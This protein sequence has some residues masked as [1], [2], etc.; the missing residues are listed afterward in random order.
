MDACLSRREKSR[1]DDGQDVEDTGLTACEWTCLLLLDALLLIG[2]AIAASLWGPVL[3]FGCKGLLC[4]TKVSHMR[5]VRPCMQSCS[6]AKF[7]LTRNS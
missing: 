7:M 5:H 1:D 3:L 2:G 6:C 4:A